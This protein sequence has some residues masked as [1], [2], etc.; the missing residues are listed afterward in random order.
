MLTFHRKKDADI[1]EQKVL[2]RAVG[3]LYRIAL[4]DGDRNFVVCS[5]VVVDD[6]HTNRS[7]V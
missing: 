3:F 6:N 1:S 2:L 4:K 5:F 7:T